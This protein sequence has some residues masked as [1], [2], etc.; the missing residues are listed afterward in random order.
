MALTLVPFERCNDC[1]RDFPP[2]ELANRNGRLVCV[3]FF[4]CAKAECDRDAWMDAKAEECAAIARYEA[5]L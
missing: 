1:G 2:G 3:D 5:G 4:D